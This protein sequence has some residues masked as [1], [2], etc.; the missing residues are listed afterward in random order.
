MELPVHGNY[1]RYSSYSKW[2]V[3]FVDWSNIIIPARSYRR[4]RECWSRLSLALART[5]AFGTI[6]THS[7]STC[8]NPILQ[9]GRFSTPA[10]FTLS[11]NLP[12]LKFF[13]RE[14]FNAKDFVKLQPI[15]VGRRRKFGFLEPL[16]LVKTVNLSSS[17]AGEIFSGLQR[18]DALPFTI[19]S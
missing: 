8:F 6:T 5:Q 9:I 11:S 18:K 12:S 3:N 17:T 2:I 7:T 14:F 1:F 10:Y 13:R 19:W 16:T 15:M 4:K